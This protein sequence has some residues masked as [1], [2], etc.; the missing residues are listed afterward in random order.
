[1]SVPDQPQRPPNWEA[2]SLKRHCEK[3]KREDPGCLEKI[4]GIASD[5]KR[6]LK[7]LLP[8]DLLKLAHEVFLDHDFQYIASTW[9]PES[10]GWHDP[11]RFHIDERLLRL[12]T[13][14]QSTEISTCY[15]IHEDHQQPC[16]GPPSTKSH[17]KA[18]IIKLRRR[19]LDQADAEH[20]KGYKPIK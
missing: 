4:A 15:H 11:S 12:I 20:I 9:D 10:N 13:N 6:F 3:R 16:P 19:L 5:P 7:E 2:G 17:A 14:I 18:E 1:M 8:G